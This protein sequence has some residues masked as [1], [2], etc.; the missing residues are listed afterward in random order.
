MRVLIG[1][2]VKTASGNYPFADR[3]QAEAYL[4]SLRMRDR[5]RQA[6]AS[7][8]TTPQQAKTRPQAGPAG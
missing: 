5:R 7:A 2:E 8:Q 3:E 1:T 6:E 4:I